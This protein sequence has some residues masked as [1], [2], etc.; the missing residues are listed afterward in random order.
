MLRRKRFLI[1]GV[2]TAAAIGYLGF[3]GLQGSTAYYYKVGELLDQGSSAYGESVR[4]NGRVA[5]GSV[6]RESSG[7]VLKFTV[8]D[9][10]KSLPVVYRGAVPDAFKEDLDVVVEGHLDSTGVFQA[11]NILTKCPS[12]YEPE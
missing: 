10:E 8:V 5:P 6:E 7:L 12:K 1:G 4:V 3:V 9:A 2:I 11:G